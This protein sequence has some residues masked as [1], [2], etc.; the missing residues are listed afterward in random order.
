MKNAKNILKHDN[1]HYNYENCALNI[2]KHYKYTNYT[3]E[4]CYHLKLSRTAR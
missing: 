2:L 4:S 1:M 3:L